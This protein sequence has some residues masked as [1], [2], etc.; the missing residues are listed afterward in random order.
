ME[1]EAVVV[2]PSSA[3]KY[4]GDP[5]TLQAPGTLTSNVVHPGE[6]LRMAMTTG[7]DLAFIDR[8]MDLQERWEA[9]QARKAF[10]QAMAKFH[11]QRIKVTRSATV[12]QGPMNG[13]PYAR[14]S[15]F[16][17]AVAEPLAAAGLSISWRLVVQE[18]D[19]LEVACVV[20]HVQGH[21]EVTRMSGPPDQSGAKN[22]IQARASTVSY[23]EKYTLKM[24]L[25]LAEQD[26]DDD[27]QG[28]AGD[29]QGGSQG[30][31]PRTPEP[32]PPPPA[33]KPGMPADQFERNFAEW[34]ALI[35]GGRDPQRI[36]AK[37]ETKYALTKE[38]KDKITAV[39]GDAK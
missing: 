6:L 14:L 26:D 37:V 20:R 31:Q 30:A 24:A 39:K 4:V 33:E 36:I 8:L 9:Q 18:K 7:R 17:G 16:V 5:L 34:K 15:D 35:E 21:E 3:L 22:A 2:E 32:P 27:G 38:Q 23:L 12:K 19:W 25:G 29:D 1:S 10:N 13:T 28:G 11:E